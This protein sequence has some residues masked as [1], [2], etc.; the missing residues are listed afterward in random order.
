MHQNLL[1][2]SR[3][4][5]TKGLADIRG[6]VDELFVGNKLKEISNKNDISLSE[7]RQIIDDKLNDV[8]IRMSKV[9][10]GEHGEKGDAGSP[11]SPLMIKSK[12]ESLN[13][14]NKLDIGFIRGLKEFFEKI[15]E[16]VNE[17][18]SRNTR[19]STGGPG[20]YVHVPMVK[21][22]TGDGSTKV[23]KLDKAPKSLDT[24]KGWGSDFPH[25]LV[26]GGGFDVVGR[27]LTIDSGT[28]APSDSARFVVEYYI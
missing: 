2:Q 20:K 4:E 28:D 22:F 11:D 12:L 21:V 18:S 19:V 15:E 10:N 9:K 6:Q 3:E 13:G 14:D 16:R 25:I 24:I 17:I 26:N 23:F 27:T 1:G 8:E 7:I 5:Q